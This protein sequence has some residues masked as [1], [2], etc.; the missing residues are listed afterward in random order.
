MTPKKAAL[1]V[2]VV[3]LFHAADRLRRGARVDYGRYLAVASAGGDFAITR[4]LAYGAQMDREAEA[5]LS[6]LRGLG[7][8]TRYRQAVVAAGRPDI[9]RTDRNV[10]IAADAWRLAGRYDVAVIGSND[11]DL[12]PLLARVRETGAQVVL[13]A[14]GVGPALA[15]LADRVVDAAPALTDHGPGT[16]V[17]SQSRGES[18]DREAGQ[19]AS[20][21][22]ADQPEPLELPADV[23]RDGAGREGGHG[24]QVARP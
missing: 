8:E 6:V 17:I 5:F 20:L 16:P 18:R 11:P 23:L 3:N 4:A 14:V 19:G 13:C 2:D 1:F 12:A 22:V 21:E 7:Y 9:R 24:H 10:A 15:G